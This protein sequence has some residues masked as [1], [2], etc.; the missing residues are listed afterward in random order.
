MI[1]NF[2]ILLKKV[3]KYLTIRMELW[4]NIFSAKK[5]FRPFHKEGIPKIHDRYFRPNRDN[6]FK[7]MDKKHVKDL[8]KE[9]SILNEEE[10]KKLKNSKYSNFFKSKFDKDSFVHMFSCTITDSTKFFKERLSPSIF[11]YK[12]NSFSFISILLRI[13][14]V[15][16]FYLIY[17]CFLFGKNDVND[18]PRLLHSFFGFLYDEEAINNMVKL[19]TPFFTNTMFFII[20]FHLIRGYVAVF[21][22][23]FFPILVKNFLAIFGVF[24]LFKLTFNLLTSYSVIIKC[25]YDTKGHLIKNVVENIDNI[26]APAYF[27]FYKSIEILIIILQFII[28][29]LELF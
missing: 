13:T 23:R 7:E 20:Y 1:K 3:E 17:M 8:M 16:F 5:N 26:L 12:G 14:G 18:F 6:M 25:Y 10:C 27:L 9:T 29:I 2:F 11:L 24:A 21:N 4:F 19:Y 15:F 28:K 22:N